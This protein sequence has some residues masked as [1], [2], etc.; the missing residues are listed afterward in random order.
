M[1]P[2]AFDPNS[3]FVSI[4]ATEHSV[5]LRGGNGPVGSAADSEQVL[6]PQTLLEG[7]PFG[8][9]N[10]VALGP[11][12]AQTRLPWL[13][14]SVTV[15]FKTTFKLCYAFYRELTSTCRPCL[16]S[17]PILQFDPVRDHMWVGTAAPRRL[18]AGARTAGPGRQYHSCPGLSGRECSESLLGYSDV[19][20]HM[21]TSHAPPKE[22]NRA[23]IVWR[24]CQ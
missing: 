2:P 6:T 19:I 11:E 24:N 13:S 20:T 18:R 21:H 5:R 10:L 22:P 17:I 12:I 15:F 3:E 7:K 4:A 9:A 1:T 8:Q 23:R 14:L 16:E